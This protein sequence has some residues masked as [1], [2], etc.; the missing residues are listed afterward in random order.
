MKPMT[1]TRE[2]VEVAYAQIDR[3]LKPSSQVRERMDAVAALDDLKEHALAI[4]PDALSPSKEE[5]AFWD[6]RFAYHSDLT[7]IKDGI[8]AAD[9]ADADL[10]ERRK[11][12][13]SP[14]GA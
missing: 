13:P 3:G 4:A 5:R 8:Q 14:H 2:E 11:R 10:A 12:F 9:A 6:A 7:D 1:M